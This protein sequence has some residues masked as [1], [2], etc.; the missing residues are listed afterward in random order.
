MLRVPVSLRRL[1]RTAL[2]G[3]L[4]ALGVFCSAAYAQSATSKP[5]P[6]HI[7]FTNGD[8]LTGRL[9][10]GVGDSIVFHSDMAG[11]LTIPLAKIKELHAAASF[12]VLRK[13][14]P[15]RNYED[16]THVA[17]GSIGVSNDTV[18]VTPHPASGGSSGTTNQAPITIPIKQVGYVV[19]LKTYDRQVAHKAG[20]LEGW[21]GTANGGITLERSTQTRS[22]YTAG[23]AFIRS[24]PLVSYFP[25]RNRS[26]LNF[27]ETYGR[28]S[29]PV[30]PQTT[31]ASPP[32]VVKTDVLHADAERDE[33]FSPRSY[34]LGELSYDHNY[35]QGLDLQQIYGFGIGLTPIKN[36]V[37]QLDIKMDVHYEKQAFQTPSTDQNLI[38]ST[39]A[40][41]YVRHLPYKL[42]LTENA[43]FIPAWNN[44]NAYSANATGILSI[45]IFKRFSSTITATDN[46][47]NNPSVGYRRNSLQLVLGV[48]YTLP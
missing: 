31:P 37:Q 44:L 13:G 1:A 4:F 6:D 45:P 39:F 38:G 19:D 36:E 9:V 34:A 43:N 15:L 5:E 16:E 48:S 35:A 22:T 41:N 29:T 10:R 26:T 40:E 14:V 42:L 47:L 7:V 25:A 33:Y 8:T 28:L 11:D 21:T 2:P 24:I 30:I 27:T 23:I 18:S 17:E 32:S 46:F 3:F 12:A 20:F